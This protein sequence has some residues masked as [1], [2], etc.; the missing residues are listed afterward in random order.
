[1]FRRAIAYFFA[2]PG[3]DAK[4]FLSGEPHPTAHSPPLANIAF[5]AALIW[6]V[7]RL[8]IASHPL[9]AGWTGMIGL[10]LLLHFGLLNALCLAWRQP[11]LMDHPM[12]SKS[13]ADF[14]GRRWNR[15]FTTLAN[16]LIF[17]PLAR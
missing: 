8:V 5:G 10:V 17:A 2:F 3:M 15:S 6:L 16:D 7:P 1:S 14:W 9:L 13:I 11:P 12:R 4:S